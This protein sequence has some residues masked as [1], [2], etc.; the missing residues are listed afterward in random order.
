MN[1]AEDA[2][3]AEEEPSR[4]RRSLRKLEAGSFK[5]GGS[6]RDMLPPMPDLPHIR[7]AGLPKGSELWRRLGVTGISEASDLDLVEALIRPYLTKDARA[8]AID[9]LAATGGD[10]GQIATL[11]RSGVG[12]FVPEGVRL[13][14]AAVVELGRRAAT[15]QAGV[16]RTRI[17]AASEAAPLAWSYVLDPNIE[18]FIVL[19]LDKAARIVHGTRLTVGSDAHTVVDPRQVL[20]QALAYPTV[21]SMIVAHNHPSGNPEPSSEDLAATRR[22]VAAGRTV[23]IDVLDHIIL[24]GPYAW[25]SLAERGMLS[26]P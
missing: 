6:S 3:G 20:R 11:L 19:L 16:P 24:A 12:P 17:R 8:V 15:R 7:I 10:L 9:L 26:A 21:T 22:L 5:A 18:Q 4:K 14:T 2:E 13:R 25:T 1:T 23:G